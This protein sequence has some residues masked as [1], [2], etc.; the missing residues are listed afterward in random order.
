M[1]I[2][3]VIDHAENARKVGLSLS[4]TTVVMFGNPRVGTLLM[5]NRREIG[6]ELP[7]RIM[8]WNSDS[9]EVYVGYRKPSNM[10]KDYGIEGNEILNK[11]DAVMESIL[12]KI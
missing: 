1:E 2:F 5:Q 3:A 4:P 12:S 8:V 6:Y 10:A 7:L 11:M 9:G